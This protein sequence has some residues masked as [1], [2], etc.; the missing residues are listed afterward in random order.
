MSAAFRRA[1]PALVTLL[2]A[3]VAALSA[4]CPTQEQPRKPA[5]SPSASA[6][7]AADAGRSSSGAPSATP[8]NAPGTASPAP[9]AA[10]P[11]EVFFAFWNVENLFDDLDDPKNHDDDENWFANDP[12]ALRQKLDNLSKGLLMMNGGKGPDILAMVEVESERVVGMLR[13]AVNAKLVKNGLADLQYR[14]VLFKDDTTGRRIAPAILTRLP[15]QADRTRKL[16]SKRGNGRILLGHVV[17]DGADLAIMVSHWT[18][19]VT[20]KTGD[21]RIEYAQDCYGEFK[22]MVLANPDIDLIVCGD[23]NDDFD[24]PSVQ[25]GLKAV[26]DPKVAREALREPRPLDLCARFDRRKGEGTAY[27]S[28]WNVFDHICVSRGLL[29]GKG[30]SCNPDDIRI[31]NP[32]EFRFG[33]TGR[34]WRF[35]NKTNQSA[36]GYA[37]HFPVTLKLRVGGGQPGPRPGGKVSDGGADF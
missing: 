11:R 36:R 18:S 13:D 3:C 17:V 2:A 37:D 4:G 29:D 6:S 9:S 5:A 8:G 23:F 12:A 34:P 19:R 31:F 28:R 10:P 21:R 26:A 22:A 32:P 16:G 1:V 7:P 20:D 30:W 35:G 14:H 24:T 33:T 15:V 27:D 25:E